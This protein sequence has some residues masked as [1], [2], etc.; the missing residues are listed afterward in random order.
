MGRKNRLEFLFAG[1]VLLQ[2]KEMNQRVFMETYFHLFKYPLVSGLQGQWELL[3]QRFPSISQAALSAV[4]PRFLAEHRDF[5]PKKSRS[6]A[7]K[8]ECFHEFSKDSKVFCWFGAR[9]S[10]HDLLLPPLGACP[11]GDAMPHP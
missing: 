5:F 2:N 11:W 8:P 7:A 9:S 6:P 1:S 4:F 10:S 3:I